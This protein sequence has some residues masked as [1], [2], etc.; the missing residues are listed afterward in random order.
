MKLTTAI[1]AAAAV[2]CAAAPLA[3]NAAA[4]AKDLCPSGQL[5]IIRTSQIKPGGSK[6]GFDKAVADN[7]AWYVAHGLTKN[8]QVG[9]TVLTF[10]KA[11]GWSASPDMVATVHVN[12]PGPEA[13]A[14][15]AAWNAFVAEYQANTNMVSQTMICLDKPLQ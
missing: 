1:A 10:D 14:A 7:Q 9:G 5:V 12:P 8:K 6:A 3:A 15:D 2:V 13:G 4:S 11:S